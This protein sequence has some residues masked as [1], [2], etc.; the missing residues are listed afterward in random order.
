MAKPFLQI[1]RTNVG[2]VSV[3][4]DGP[5]AECCGGLKR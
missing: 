2:S 1:V 4:R 3:Y 5:K